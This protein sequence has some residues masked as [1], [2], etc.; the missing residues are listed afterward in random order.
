[1]ED[2]RCIARAEQETRLRGSFEE[3]NHRGKQIRGRIMHRPG[4]TG[5]RACEAA[6]IRA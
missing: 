3:A 4:R 5:K 2:L 1:M 6:L